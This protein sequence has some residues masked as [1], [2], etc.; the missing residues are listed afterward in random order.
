[1]GK[2]KGGREDAVSSPLL[3][4]LPLNLSPSLLRLA[5][6][7]DKEKRTKGTKKDKRTKRL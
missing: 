4:P 7:R 6:M 3:L 1:M 5:G 2:K